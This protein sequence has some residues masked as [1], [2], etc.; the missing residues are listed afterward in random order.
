MQEVV[1]GLHTCSFSLTLFFYL[2]WGLSLSSYPSFF[3]FL[4]GQD[5]SI[6]L[7][8]I[9]S[10]CKQNVSCTGGCKWKINWGATSRLVF[11]DVLSVHTQAEASH[12]LA[13]PQ[14]PSHTCNTRLGCWGQE[15]C[16]LII[17]FF[18]F[19][20]AGSL[21]HSRAD[22]IARMEPLP[23]TSSRPDPNTTPAERQRKDFSHFF[24]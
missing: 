21:L 22:C 20:A 5:G 13:A 8:N 4:D 1:Q 9:N 12:W 10:Q 15:M 2:P 6:S 14:K 11:Y 19:V 3:L 16:L 17:L 18:G 7:A 24:S 23:F